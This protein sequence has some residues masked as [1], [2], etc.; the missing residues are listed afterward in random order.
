[1]GNICFGR[2]D[3]VLQLSGVP[4]EELRVYQSE[5]NLRLNEVM[6]SD[7]FAAIKRFGF[8]D[9]LNDEHLEKIAPEILLDYNEME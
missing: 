3:K 6:Y 7:F 4:P 1:M 2:E 8:V 9:D 5:C